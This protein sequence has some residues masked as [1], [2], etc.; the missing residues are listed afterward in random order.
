MAT[1]AL[2][3]FR[4]FLARLAASARRAAAPARPVPSMQQLA[5]RG[6]L[7]EAADLL[8]LARAVKRA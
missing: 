4:V 3:S 5:E 6:Q 1:Q 7:M 8:T 2:P